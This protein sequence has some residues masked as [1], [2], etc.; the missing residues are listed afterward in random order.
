MTITVNNF[1]TPK[2]TDN[3]LTDPLCV[4]KIY[5]FTFMN[6]T[7]VRLLTPYRIHFVT[8][9]YFYPLMKDQTISGFCEGFPKT[10]HTGTKAVHSS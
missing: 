6:L 4:M 10:K 9:R 8:H 2:I 7:K 1:K 3:F 5:Y